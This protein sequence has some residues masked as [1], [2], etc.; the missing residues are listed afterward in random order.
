[1]AQGDLEVRVPITAADEVGDL[2][3]RFNEMVEG[4]LQRQRLEQAFGTYVHPSL[5]GKVMAGEVELPGVEMDV[6]VMFADIRG[7]TGLAETLAPQ[8]AVA[9]LNRFFDVATSVVEEYGGHV[10]RF[11]GDGLLAVFGAPD[12]LEGHADRALEAA[13]D[14]VEAV[15]RELGST[16]RIGIGLNSGQVLAGSVGGGGHLEF[17]VIGDAVNVA[18][19]LESHTKATGDAV[20]LSDATRDRLVD[21]REFVE[22]RETVQ[23]RG[24]SAPVGIWAPMRVSGRA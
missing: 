9:L 1:V 14:L 8:D 22:S 16:I 10:N 18:A 7:F 20:L 4:L 12:A 13:C 23:I 17:T 11:L 19:R 21:L 24:R 6:T 2:T 3:A 5:A 15:G